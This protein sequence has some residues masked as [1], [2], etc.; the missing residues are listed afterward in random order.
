[1]TGPPPIEPLGWDEFC[2]FLFLVFGSWTIGFF[3]GRDGW[4]WWPTFTVFPL[5]TLWIA[6]DFR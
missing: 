2:F 5:L 4:G 1:M 3:A 6:W